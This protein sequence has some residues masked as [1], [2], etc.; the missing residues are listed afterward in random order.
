MLKYQ[1]IE[2]IPEDFYA[3]I[4]GTGKK[5]HFTIFTNAASIKYHD[6]WGDKDLIKIIAEIGQASCIGTLAY[7]LLA[8]EHKADFENEE[9]FNNKLQTYYAKKSDLDTKVLK[10]CAIGFAQSEADDKDTGAAADG[11]RFQAGTKDGGADSKTAKGNWFERFFNI[12]PKP[13]T[14]ANKVI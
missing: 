14:D 9:D 8:P 7:W 4:D 10:A 6:K 12:K 13:A 2:V 5:Y 11:G 1:A 3:E